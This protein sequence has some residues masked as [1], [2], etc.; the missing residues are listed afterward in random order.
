MSL[1]GPPTG[2]TRLSLRARLVAMAMLCLLS[3]GV[4]AA[5]EIEPFVGKF[6]GFATVEK[7]SGTEQRNMSVEIR[8][9]KKGFSVRWTTAI[10]SAS[11]DTREKSYDIRFVPSRRPGIY[12]SAMKTNV[13]GHDVPLDPLA[14]EPYVWARIQGDT[15][16]VQSLHIDEAGDF[17][18]QRYDRRLV[19]EGLHL[20]FIRIRDSDA[21]RT[22]STLLQRQ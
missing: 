18:I 2:I 5:D 1:H 16:T 22:I 12:A 20:D 6:A 11:G 10:L 4:L 13:F 3:Q 21:E 19:D 8:K 15:L 7:A 14:G 9:E 17:E